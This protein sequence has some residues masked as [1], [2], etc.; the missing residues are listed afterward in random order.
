MLG[1]GSA[2][3]NICGQVFGAG[4]VD[5][6]VFTCKEH[7]WIILWMMTRVLLLLVCIFATIQS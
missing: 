2:S 3:E 5:M 1:T 7:A 4:Q 6:L